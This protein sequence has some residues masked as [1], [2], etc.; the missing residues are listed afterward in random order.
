MPTF[1]TATGRHLAGPA[2]IDGSVIKGAGWGA[3]EHPFGYGICLE[4]PRDVTISDNT[5]YAARLTTISGSYAPA[6]HTVITG[7]I[8]DLTAA[9]D[10]TQ[11]FDEAVVLRGPGCVF[12]RNTVLAGA[13]SGISLYLKRASRSRVAGNTFSD[14]RACDNPAVIMLLDA[15][16]NSLTGNLLETAADRPPRIVVIGDSHDNTIT[17]NTFTHQ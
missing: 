8:I 17:G 13:R 5:I 11:T 2:L 1:P 12:A 4:A 14:V 9:N 16:Y 10:V 3:V 7:N 6:A 15:S